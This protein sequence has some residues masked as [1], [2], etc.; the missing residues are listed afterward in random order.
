MSE[1]LQFKPLL[2]KGCVSF[3]ENWGKLNPP[4]TCKSKRMN[5]T[6]YQSK[7]QQAF[8]PP[9]KNQAD[10]KIHMKIL[11]NPGNLEELS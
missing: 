8:F 2:F 5:S 9:P 6:Q 7:S 1:P 4:K 3:H 10:L 11:K